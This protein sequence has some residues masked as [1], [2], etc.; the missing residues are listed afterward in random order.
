MG[1]IINLILVAVVI[2]GAL[3]TYDMKRKAEHAADRVASLERE[4]A[5][6]KDRIAML[7][8]QWSVLT[9]PGR[10]QAI[11]EQ[12]KDTFKL[13]PFSATQVA[14]IGEIPMR[15]VGGGEDQVQELLARMG[16]EG[17]LGGTD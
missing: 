7:K 15:P 6:E 12:H 17:A 11:V 10:L 3:I 1:R 16:I 4:I 8:A 2:V 14:T 9:Q 13:A 5:A